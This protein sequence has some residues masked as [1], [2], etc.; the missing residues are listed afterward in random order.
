[1]SYSHCSRPASNLAQAS[2]ERF[3]I[4]LLQRLPRHSKML[5]LITMI[6]TMGVQQELQER[7]NVAI[8]AEEGEEATLVEQAF[9]PLKRLACYSFILCR[10]LWILTCSSLP[11]F[12]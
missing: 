1:M 2:T 3:Q 12:A 5:D 7:K 4:A 10:A 6:S 9:T 11:P 8:S